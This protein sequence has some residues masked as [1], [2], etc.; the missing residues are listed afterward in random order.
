MDKKSIAG[1]E[2]EKK[3]KVFKPFQSVSLWVTWMGG[4][5]RHVSIIS[6]RNYNGKIKRKS[7][8]TVYISV[9]L[10]KLRYPV[11]FTTYSTVA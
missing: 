7:L 2:Y 8:N 6:H 4:N 10:M 1:I 3:L 9:A 5:I 11:G